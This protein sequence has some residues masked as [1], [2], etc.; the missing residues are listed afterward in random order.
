[1]S[2]KGL[3]SSLII[4]LVVTLSLGI[5][6]LI[7]VFGGGSGVPE[8]PVNTTI[9]VAFRTGDSTSLFEG[10]SAEDVVFTLAEG[11]ENPL[12]L[13]EET[14]K[15]NAVAEGEVTAVI[16]LDEKGN[17][18]TIIIKVYAQGAGETADAPYILANVE[19]LQEFAQMVNTTSA[20]RNVPAN[21]K[22]V[23]DIDLSGIDWKPIGGQ[24]NT[25][26]TGNFDGNGYTIKNLTINVN[27]SNYQD[28]IA[29]STFDA[30]PRAFLDLGF[31]GKVENAT[32]S[33][34]NFE[35]ANIN[36]SAD[37]YSIINEAVSPEG[38]E[39]NY[40]ARLTVGTIA[41]SAYNTVITGSEEKNTIVSRITGYS[42]TTATNGQAHG[43][44]GVVGVAQLV[45]TSNYNVKTNII[46]NIEETKESYIGGVYGYATSSYLAGDTLTPDASHQ[47]SI[48][49]VEVDFTATVLY[50]NN[51]T[52]GGVVGAGRNMSL[53]NTNVA[54]FKIVDTSARN[55][56]DYTLS[57]VTMVAGVAG[58]FRNTATLALPEFTSV[59]ENVTVNNIDVFMLGGD[60]VGVVGVAGAV[61][62]SGDVYET[63]VIKDV[64]ASGSIVANAVAGFAYQ[65]NPGATISYTKAY[66]APVVKVDIKAN[67]SAGFVF[68][69]FGVIN[70]YD[71]EGVKTQVEVTTTGMGGLIEDP[72]T[73]NIGLSRESSYATGF[74]GT[75]ETLVSTVNPTISN[76]DIVFKASESINYS[77][78][79]FKLE[80]ATISNVNVNADVTSFNYSG[81]ENNIST[82]YMVAG[83]V[84]SAGAG[85]D[86]QNVNIIINA[87][88]NVADKTLKYGA[89]FFGGVVARYT[90]DA[91]NGLTIN[92]CSVAGDVYF[93]ASYENIVFEGVTYNVFIAG[94]LVGA[95]EATTTTG[96]QMYVDAYAI[97]SVDKSVITANTVAGLKITADFTTEELGNQGWRVRAI[98]ALVG[99]INE[100][101]GDVLDLSTN[102]IGS[103]T[104]NVEIVADETT[105]T[106]SY[107]GAGGANIENVTLGG[108]NTHSYGSSYSWNKGAST[109]V[110]PVDMSKVVYS[111]IA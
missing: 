74:V 66:E 104:A 7:S 73:E 100:E 70:G 39:F 36:V 13:D 55:S 4:G 65:L 68:F 22:L 12:V 50:K 20:E 98:G 60:A 30:G 84:A 5:Y 85:A 62:T 45:R 46:N 72:T 105:F 26:Y 24:G 52:V 111:A 87:N 35:N 10:Y 92:N 89:T 3:L 64:T 90:G 71:V 103:E 41:G 79:A 18:K 97:C 1:M 61:Y 56:I 109:V 34:L 53:T 28:L 93:N 21:I 106:Y 44:G 19:H 15:Y 40:V 67:M 32:I 27:S 95:M 51:A 8:G 47:T 14:G 78:V 43:I 99:V 25:A 94:G 6:T 49:N 88:T 81:N 63:T 42:T 83:V 102:V 91:E 48:D 108:N 33:N 58:I 31:F 38:A 11:A 69:N 107:D 96:S 59:M 80:N 37:L 9:N 86:I 110:D 17:T 82:T 16:T 23:S 2:K 54:G 57:D 75:M 77:G 76:F 29:I 101:D